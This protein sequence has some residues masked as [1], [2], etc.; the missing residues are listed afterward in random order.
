MGWGIVAVPL[1]KAMVG[2]VVTLRKSNNKRDLATANV[3]ESCAAQIERTVEVEDLA[4][5]QLKGDVGIVLR[6]YFKETIREVRSITTNMA[7]LADNAEEIVK[8]FQEVDQALD[9]LSIE[10]KLPGTGERG[11]A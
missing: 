9:A 4:A 3:L 2:A 5:S 8:I 11:E 7:A 1:V 6:Q 10:L